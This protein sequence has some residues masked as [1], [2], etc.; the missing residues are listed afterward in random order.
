MCQDDQF[1]RKKASAVALEN[2][3]DIVIK[4]CQDVVAT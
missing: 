3:L 4:G 2:H 1:D